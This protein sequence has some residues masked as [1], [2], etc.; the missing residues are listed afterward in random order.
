MG[1]GKF[2]DAKFIKLNIPPRRAHDH[3]HNSA[4]GDSLEQI[5]FNW[6]IQ[7]KRSLAH[8]GTTGDNL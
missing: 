4:V 3:L 7:L 1:S 5:L 6:A 8:V 2:L